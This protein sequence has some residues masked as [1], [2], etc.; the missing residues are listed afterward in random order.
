MLSHRAQKS[1]E[2]A[3]TISLGALT[4]GMEERAFG[5]LLLLLALPC[6]LPFVYLLPQIVAMPMLLLVHICGALWH[7]F[8][9]R[10]GVLESMTVPMR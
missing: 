9:R 8:V 3:D 2:D 4:D 5:L 7:K 10:D 1:V 6:G